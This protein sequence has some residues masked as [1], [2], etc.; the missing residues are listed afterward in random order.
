M[1]KDIN[2]KKNALP[3]LYSRRSF[4]H[5]TLGGALALGL[6]GCD[7]VED[8]LET[9]TGPE[10]DEANFVSFNAQYYDATVDSKT[11]FPHSAIVNGAPT[12]FTDP[13][14]IGY[15]IQYLID[16][17]DPTS[18]E[19]ILDG[20]LEAQ[21]DSITFVN[22]RGFIPNLEF[23]DNNVGFQKSD[24]TFRIAD[25]A[26]LSARIAMAASAF[27]DTTLQAKAL[28][29]LNNQKEGY[30]YYLAGGESLHFPVA[31]S[32]L[33]NTVGGPQ[34]DLLFNEFYA[35]LAFALSYFIGDSTSIADPQVGLSAWQ[36]LSSGNAIPTSQHVDSFSTLIN[37]SV[38]LSKN[39]SGYQYFTPLL[40]I[41]T[42]SIGPALTNALYNVLYSFLDSARFANLPGIYSGGPNSQGLFLAEN[43]LS[44]LAAPENQA[45][46]RE[47]VVTV[48][49]L[50]A[51]M[52]LFP[53]GSVERQTLRRW[54]GVY[55]EVPGIQATNGL[56]GSVDEAGNV[57]QALFARQNAAMILVNSPAPDHLENFLAANG[58]TSLA[59]MFASIDFTVNSAQLAR[60][61]EVL[62]LPPVSASTV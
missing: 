30:N 13:A 6:A 32:S 11:L 25:N 35:E 18:I 42:A 46:T 58:K 15:R 16:I 54:I 26:A 62:P 9:Y 33:D 22:Y 31:G 40:A 36:A 56:Y 41:P 19:A 34:I 38:P 1:C 60:L 27:P 37:V 12:G 53:E 47:L 17:G 50:A 23:A 39:G 57:A 14:T 24:P 51:A 59:D 44:R 48:D 49:P 43:G 45:S 10:I 4:I 21:T 61:Q 29:F 28:N 52:R 3:P 5:T 20:L 55:N 8:G 7:Q 2:L